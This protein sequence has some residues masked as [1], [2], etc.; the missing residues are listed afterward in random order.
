MWFESKIWRKLVKG[1]GHSEVRF[2]IF[3]GHCNKQLA[4]DI[5]VEK[6]NEIG[7][8]TFKPMEVFCNHKCAFTFQKENKITLWN[9]GWRS[10][11][12]L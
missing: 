12:G 9:Y 10:T 7:F 2:D 1:G 3:C 5:K 6:L 8:Q 11:F 4:E